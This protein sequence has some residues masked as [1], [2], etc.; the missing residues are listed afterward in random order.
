MP[1][2]LVKL[3]D[4]PDVTPI[5][6]Q[7]KA[8]G[9]TVRNAMPYEKHQV[10]DWIRAHFGP[11]WASEADVSF[12]NKPVSCLIATEAGSIAGFACYETTCRAYFG[13]TGVTTDKRGRGIGKALLFAA[14]RGL[15]DMGYAYAFIGSAGPV[16]FYARAL[17]A[18]PIP[19]S[20]PG[21]YRDRLKKPEAAPRL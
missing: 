10:L 17:G 1:D 15:A 5:L 8:S 16:E 11:D 7:L 9:V 13:P 6:K 20:T 2:M 12:A 4:L 3:Y 18:I 14:M 21:I 19:G